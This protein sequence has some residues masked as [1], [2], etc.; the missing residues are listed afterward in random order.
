MT[1]FKVQ[2]L[3]KIKKFSSWQLEIGKWKV[4]RGQ[5]LITLLFFV[6]IAV[7][8]TSAAVVII[9]VDSLSGTKLQESEIAYEIAESG[10]ENAQLRLLRDPR[11]TG[12]T[13]SVGNGTATIQVNTNGNVYTVISK[14]QIGNFIRQI[15][16]SGT[17][18]NN[19]FTVTSQQEI[20]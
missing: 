18:T 8:I 12:E 1:H 10:I 19:I 5:A 2:I 9:L 11:Y 3:K 7:T 16:M 17:Y 14:G 6:I 4:N 13:V 20:F 15:Q